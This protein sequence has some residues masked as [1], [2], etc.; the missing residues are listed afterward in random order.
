MAISNNI[1]FLSPVGFK[2]V[3]PESR[4]KGMEFYL[5][6]LDL[7]LVSIGESS[8]NIPRRQL[9]IAGDTMSYEP[10][11]ANIMC[12][13]NMDNFYEMHSWLKSIIENPDTKTHVTDM[14][15]V[16]LGSSNHK[17]RIVQFRN[18]FP[19]SMSGIAFDS[20]AT[21][22]QYASFSVTFR[23][24]YFDISQRAGSNAEFPSSYPVV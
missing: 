4:F 2:L 10:F 14:N 9:M 1:N 21:E 7:P 6:S 3:F 22:V 17:V 15:L 5:Q 12:D 19:T 20:G 13:E 8:Y 24:D 23:Y 16:I 11:T 18:A